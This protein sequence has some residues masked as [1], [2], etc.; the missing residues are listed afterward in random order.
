MGTFEFL[1]RGD[2]LTI[3]LSLRSLF[4]PTSASLAM[5]DGE[6]SADL[7]VELILLLTSA[8]PAMSE[9]KFSADLVA[10]VLSIKVS[11]PANVLKPWLKRQ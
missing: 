7:V 1:K 4:R 8:F 2:L 3:S 9:G 11:G 5:F 10:F 6:F